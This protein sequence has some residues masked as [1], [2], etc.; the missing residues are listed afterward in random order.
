MPTVNLAYVQCGRMKK[1]SDRNLEQTWATLGGQLLHLCWHFLP[2]RTLAF[3]HSEKLSLYRK[4]TYLDSIL[5]NQK[6]FWSR[7]IV[8]MV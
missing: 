8:G 3:L 5:V 7:S 4:K 6:A 2:V 1:R